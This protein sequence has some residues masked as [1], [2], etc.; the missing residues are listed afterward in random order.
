[1]RS[2]A[3]ACARTHLCEHNGQIGARARAATLPE[4]RMTAATAARGAHCRAVE[5]RLLRYGLDR[6]RGS[7]A[8]LTAGL[9][10]SD[11]DSLI[12]IYRRG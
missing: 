12:E 3:C 6:V 8:V 9:L 4:S 2:G 5:R 7:A 10:D 11:L 1:M